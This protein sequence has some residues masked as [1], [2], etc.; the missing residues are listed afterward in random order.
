LGRV[1]EP[2]DVFLLRGPFGAGKT[3]FVQGLARGLDVATPVTSPSFVLA[4]EHRGRLPLTHVDLF[5]IDA[6]EEALLASLHETL[7]GDGVCAV[8]WPERLPLPEGLAATRVSITPT[9]DARRLEI[10]PA[11]DRQ[12][13]VVAAFA[14]TGRGSASAGG[15]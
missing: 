6:P 5:R 3:V 7:E 15:G 9:D 1:A 14:A 10:S 8:E 4:A 13:R 2:G 12:A 11:A